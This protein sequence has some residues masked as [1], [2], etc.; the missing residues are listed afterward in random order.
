MQNRTNVFPFSV[1]NSPSDG[2][3]GQYRTGSEDGTVP[4]IFYANV[5]RPED[6]YVSLHI[7]IFVP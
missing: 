5:R 1:K 3:S 7:M 4:G 6:K 2:I